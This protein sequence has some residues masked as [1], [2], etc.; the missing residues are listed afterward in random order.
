MAKIHK[1]TKDGQ[2][3]YPATTTDAVVHPT[4]RK[5]LTEELFD[6]K[7]ENGSLSFFCKNTPSQAGNI[8]LRCINLNLKSGSYLK[9]RVDTLRGEATN[10]EMLSYY[11]KTYFDKTQFNIGE[12]YVLPLIK[13]FETDTELVLG[14]YIKN[15]KPHVEAKFTAIINYQLNASFPVITDKIADGAITTAKIADNSID[16][17]LIHI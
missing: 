3:I 11:G 4:S 13:D 2:T 1:L 7:K 5:N 17:S 8:D 16:L 12:E 9:F 14:A 15:A 10:Y 6:L